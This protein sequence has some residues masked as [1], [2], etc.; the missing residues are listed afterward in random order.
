MNKLSKLG[1]VLAVTPFVFAC[2]NPPKQ[3]SSLQPR[4]GYCSE[5]KMQEIYPKDSKSERFRKLKENTYFQK[6]CS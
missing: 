1:L 5:Y 6:V 3:T 4:S 2:T